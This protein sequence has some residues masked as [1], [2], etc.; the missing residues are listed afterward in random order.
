MQ[1][2]N[3]TLL[4]LSGKEVAAKRAYDG[5]LVQQAV[6]MAGGPL[7]KLFPVY[8]LIGQADD[9]AVKYRQV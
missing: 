2:P 6:S 1:D 4:L 9:I 3:V 7:R 8:R 5:G